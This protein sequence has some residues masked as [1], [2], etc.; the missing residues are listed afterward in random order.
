MRASALVSVRRASAVGEE[1]MLL[2]RL[3]PIEFVL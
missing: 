2:E 1:V 3:E